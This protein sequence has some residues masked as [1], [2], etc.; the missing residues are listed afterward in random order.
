MEQSQLPDE[1]VEVTIADLIEGEVVY[2]VPWALFAD[3][4]GNLWINGNFSFDHE[5]HGTLHMMIEK[6]GKFIAVVKKTIG[7]YRFSKSEPSFVG[8]AN[9]MPVVLV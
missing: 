2:T 8:G 5:P 3:G 6:R 4:D 9:W 1:L 7:D